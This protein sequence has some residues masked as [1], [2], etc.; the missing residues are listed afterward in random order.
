M[1]PIWMTVA[2]LL[3]AAQTTV[4]VQPDAPRR[5]NQPVLRI[6][7]DYTLPASDSA[8]EI[9]VIFGDA[10]IEGRVDRNVVVVF[11]NARLAGTA[12]IDGS[13]V[14]VGGSAVAAEGARVYE[15]LFVG[16]GTFEAPPGF[17]PNGQQVVIGT[18]WLGGRLRAIVPWLTRGLLWGRP[19]VPDL[20]WVWAIVGIFFVVYL[21][22]NVL[23]DRPVRASAAVL[24]EKPL[25][26]FMVGLLVLLLAGPVCLLLAVSVIGIAVVPFVMCA[27]FVAA[28]L[29]K[30]AVSRWIGMS[31]VPE[32]PDN[33][34][35][36]LRSFI[37]G[38]IVIVL[39]YMVPILGFVTWTLS[40]MFGLGA[41]SLA[42]IRAYRRENP[43]PPRAV[44]EPVPA[45]VTAVVPPV[46]QYQAAPLEQADTPVVTVTGPRV[47][48]VVTLPHAA[49][50]DRLTA[51]ALDVFLVLIAVQIFSWTNDD[52]S[53]RAFFVALLGYHIAF[54]TWKGT[55]VGGI[56]C[57]LRVIRVDGTP[58]RF[59]DA[60][61]RGLS[62]IFSLAAFGL[63]ALWILKDPERQ[64]WHDRIAGTY[65][66]KVPRNWPL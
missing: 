1:K 36:S 21:L 26:A 54:W 50:L 27:L 57:Q 10:S 13:L 17:V 33:R 45:P 34:L 2:A 58:L 31:A 60:L 12:V 47:A 43:A 24:S 20:P 61:V 48:D 8:R 63:G 66:V 19:I 38:S 11:G 14:V 25:S 55:T 15:D 64:A 35:H 18:A 6:G 37:I 30:I 56:I 32:E 16:G 42:F 51:F 49:F 40:G 52:D 3:F 4:E 28:I 46:A 44:P 9:V 5:W 62:A 29:G 7:Q 65:V 22:L 41:A 23:F 59:V 39:A 53:A